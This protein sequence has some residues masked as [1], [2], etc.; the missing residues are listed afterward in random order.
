M[1][2]IQTCLQ[3]FKPYGH[4]KLQNF[5]L[6]FLQLHKCEVTGGTKKEEI[7]MRILKQFTPI[8]GFA[9]TNAWTHFHHHSHGLP[10]GC[11]WPALNNLKIL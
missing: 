3:N 9:P 2:K 8:W 6:I 4:E 5:I 1:N 11:T 10:S 7:K